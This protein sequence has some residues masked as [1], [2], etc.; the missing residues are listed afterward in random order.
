VTSVKRWAF[1]ILSGAGLFF[2]IPVAN[3]LSFIHPTPA[4]ESAFLKNYSPKGVIEQ[5]QCK[6]RWFAQADGASASGGRKFVSRESVFEPRF[7]IKSKD[8]MPL[9]AALS[10]DLVWQLAQHGAE[11]LT[12]TGDPHDGYRIQYQADKSVGEVA[13]QPLK[14]I[15]SVSMRGLTASLA[16]DEK[17]VDV[18]ITIQEKWFKVKPGMITVKVSSLAN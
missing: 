15:D 18:R 16:D 3:Y 6:N 4:N 1:V 5:F 9:M 8:W 17:T 12:Q 11:I 14:L 13:I 2:L 10:Q 7:V